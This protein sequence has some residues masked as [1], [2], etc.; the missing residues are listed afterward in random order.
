MTSLEARWSLLTISIVSQDAQLAR[1]IASSQH[2]P[3]LCRK[4]F[5]WKK[6]INP[7]R[8]F[9]LHAYK[10]PDPFVITNSS[11]TTCVSHR[12]LWFLA[13]VRR[14]PSLFGPCSSHS[15]STCSGPGPPDG[16]LFTPAKVH[17]PQWRLEA[18]DM[19]LLLTNSVSFWPI[20]SS[21]TFLNSEF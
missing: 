13:T 20:Q 1:E 7:V 3:L 10:T 18:W 14:Q 16:S 5:V 2:P 6:T 19:N 11:E 12:W 9:S 21:F 15:I 8:D 17:S 4:T